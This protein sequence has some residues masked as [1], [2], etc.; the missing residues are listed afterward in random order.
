MFP[1][2]RVGDLGSGLP[3][4]TWWHQPTLILKH[5]IIMRKGCVK[6]RDGSGTV[7]R[8]VCPLLH[9]WLP[10]EFFWLPKRLFSLPFGPACSLTLTWCHCPQA[11]LVCWG[12]GFTDSG[13][14]SCFWWLGPWELGLNVFSACWRCLMKRAISVPSLS[15]EIFFISFLFSQIFCLL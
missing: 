5:R 13:L 15:G 1:V 6:S 2:L 7:S 10:M 11:P 9:Y 12:S 3:G 4:H 8:R 14:S